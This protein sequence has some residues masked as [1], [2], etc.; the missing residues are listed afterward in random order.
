MVGNKKKSRYV[1]NQTDDIKFKWDI[2]III[3]VVFNCFTIP[4]EIS[5]APPF[6]KTKFFIILNLVVDF[7]FFADIL[8]TFRTGY[9][10]YYGVECTEPK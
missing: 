9:V 2:V 8:I 1:I 7:C 5:F 6:M 10:D 4:F 3:M